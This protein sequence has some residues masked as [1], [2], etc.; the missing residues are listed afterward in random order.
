MERNTRD[1]ASQRRARTGEASLRRDGALFLRIHDG[2]VNV[3]VAAAELPRRRIDPRRLRRRFGARPIHGPWNSSRAEEDGAMNTWK[4]ARDSARKEAAGEL[5]AALAEHADDFRA[6]SARIATAMSHRPEAGLRHSNHG[7]A[8]RFQALPDGF[9]GFE[10]GDHTSGGFPRRRDEQ[11]VEWR[12]ELAVHDD[13]NWVPS[14]DVAHRELRIVR[15]DRV[16][17]DH[18]RVIRRAEGVH[19]G[20]AAGP[21]DPLRDAGARRNATIERNGELQR[22]VRRALRDV[23][24]PRLDDPLGAL[25]QYPRDDFDARCS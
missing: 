13:A 22:Q 15:E 24:G 18:H 5:R 25:F 19:A 11:A 8:R 16:D 14:R 21:R 23:F 6:A 10:R 7:D 1:Q 9:G 17:A 2:A 12:P 20:P 4:L 3:S